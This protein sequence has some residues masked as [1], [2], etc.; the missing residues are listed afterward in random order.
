MRRIASVA[1]RG[2]FCIGFKALALES[3]ALPEALAEEQHAWSFSGAYTGDLLRNS[4]GG[5]AVGNAYLDNLELALSVDGD[6]AF[7]VAG[8]RLFASALYNNAARFSEDF[9][10][11]AMIA[12]NIDAPRAVR[13][14]EAWADWSPGWGSLSFRLGLY[15]LNSEFDLSD[16]RGLMINSSFGVGHDL[17]Q[18]GTNGP[19]IF[20]STSLALRL[21]FNPV[22]DWTFIAAV[23]DGVPGDPDDPART[24]IHLGGDDG[25][26]FIVELHRKASRFTKVAAGAWAYSEEFARI[27]DSLLG[28][29]PRTSTSSG[30]YALADVALWQDATNP[31]RTIESFAR[32]GFASDSVNRYDASMQFGLLFNQP[33]KSRARESLG[34]AV[35]SART[36]EPYR[37]AQDRLAAPVDAAETAIEVTYRRE[38]LPWLTLQPDIQFIVNPGALPSQQDALVFGLRFELTGE[39]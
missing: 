35:T 5:L 18:T 23:L 3:G 37:K 7:G 6:V 13:M 16:A 24:R 2:A 21:A 9:S 30:A 38:I 22:E 17:A 10:G 32:I 31:R 27:D 14:Y 1:P 39:L 28:A 33:F 20:P 15:D 26:L 36:G 19:S 11:D 25:A 34:L 8:L 29:E 12:S 4:S